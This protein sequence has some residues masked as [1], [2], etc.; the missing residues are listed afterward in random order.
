MRRSASLSPGP[1]LR[2]GL[3][4]E[5]HEQSWFY[6]LTDISLRKLEIQIDA[7]FQSAQ[8]KPPDSN[9]VAREIFYRDII[10]TLADSDK[11]IVDH[12]SNLPPMISVETNDSH[13]S[14]DDLREYLRLRM[15]R[16]RHD[17]SR[18]ALYFILHDV[19]AGLSASLWGQAVD[20]A[21]RAL[22]IDEYLMHHGLSTHR[23]PGTWLGIRYCTRSALELFAVSQASIPELALP[24][25][26][27]SG[28]EKFKTALKY[29]GGESRD[30]RLYLEWIAR[31]ESMP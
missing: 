28:M 13:H 17:L 30:V 9:T 16:I 22:S 20:M 11:Q 3:T 27:R 2:R 31:L 14:P 10:T 5:E 12:F 26:W 4:A 29:W 1:I 18:P 7:F 21:N 15:L 23:H 19:L 8:A 24:P 6:Y 25:R